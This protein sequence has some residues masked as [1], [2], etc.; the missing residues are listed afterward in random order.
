MSRTGIEAKPAWRTLPVDVRRA[1]DDAL[2]GRVVRAMRI[3]GG[4]SATPTFRLRLADGRR[5]FFKATTQEASDFARDAHHRE[6]RVYREMGDII[7]SWAPDFYGGFTAA[8]WDVMLLQDLGP[9]SAPPWRPPVLRGVTLGLA[10]FHRATAGLVF[11]DWLPRA[12]TLLTTDDHTWRTIEAQGLESVGQLAG[13]RRDE[14]LR[15]CER[16]LPVLSA[17]SRMLSEIGAPAA[18]LHRDVRSDNLR[19]HEKQLK[20]LDWPHTG[21]GPAEYDAVMFAESVAVEGAA[22]PED[23]MQIYAQIM[24]VRSEAV[25]AASAVLAS[26]FATHAP[27][28]DIPGLPRLRAFQRAQLKVMLAWAAR[29][30]DLP[31]PTWLETMRG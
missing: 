15:W 19:W 1:V 6:E 17:R 25:D 30:F 31:A 13:D 9:K 16:A 8:G 27:Q 22:A 21:A 10:S 12:S 2:G 11:P 18:L 20:L 29:R 26:I 24:P 23:V 5:A 4:Y 3:W 14:A 28:P 7:A